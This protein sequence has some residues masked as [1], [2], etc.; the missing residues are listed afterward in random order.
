MNATDQ[1]PR[2]ATRPNARHARTTA[3][4]SASRAGSS[5]LAIG[6]SRFTGCSRSCGASRTS[7]ARYDALEAA[8][9]ATKATQALEP[10]ARVPDLAREQQAREQEKVLRP[11]PRAQRDERGARDRARCGDGG[12]GHRPDGRRLARRPAAAAGKLRSGHHRQPQ[13]EPAARAEL[14]LEL[15][16]AAERDRQL[17]GDR[18]PEPGAAAVPR[19]E[20]PEDPLAVGRL[21]PR[22]GVRDRDRDGAV[23][24]G[25]RELD[26]TAVGRPPEG[27]GEQVGDDLEHPVTVGDDHRRTV[28]VAAVVD[29]AGVSPP[30][31]RLR[32]PARPGAPCPPPRA[33]P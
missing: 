18:Q 12:H 25:E 15:D 21:D 16:A 13:V 2:Y 5:P 19:P 32:T 10:Q 17:A 20:R 33:A 29:L 31:R 3:S 22:S 28:A 7:L 23:R 6:R 1:G 26:P 30:R 11:L 24:G 27:V 8:Q 9:Y 14:A 4:A